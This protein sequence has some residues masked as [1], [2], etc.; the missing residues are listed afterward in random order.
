[1]HA[2]KAYSFIER[3]PRLFLKEEERNLIQDLV[4]L[5]PHWLITVMKVIV[6]IKLITRNNQIANEHIRPLKGGV[7]CMEIFELFLREFISGSSDNIITLDHLL[8][9]L[10]SYCLIFPLQP[11]PKALSSP[12]GAEGGASYTEYIVPCKLPDDLDDKEVD[13]PEGKCCVFYFNFCRFL[14]D[15]IYHRLMCLASGESKPGMEERN[16]FSKQRCVFY[17]LHGTN[18]IIKLEREKHRMKFSFL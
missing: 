15:E 13:I 9:I 14:P 16:K 8:L 18:W 7:A 4:I 10:R 5:H 2:F 1:M 11:E 6:E 17:N 3:L 12:E